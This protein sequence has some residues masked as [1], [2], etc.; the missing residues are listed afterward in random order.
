MRIFCKEPGIFS[1]GE[2][3]YNELT[4]NKLQRGKENEKKKICSN[5]VCLL[6]TSDLVVRRFL[7]VLYPPCEY[8]QTSLRV[9]VGG[10]TFAARG[11]IVQK[12]GWKAVYELSLIH[13]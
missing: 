6:Y 10:E 8:L 7:A 2:D 1:N 13:I 5:N 3:S 12:P 11:N 9:D 4:K